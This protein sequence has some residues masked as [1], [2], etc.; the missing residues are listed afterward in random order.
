VGALCAD[1]PASGLVW[2]RVSALRQLGV[3][4]RCA[5]CLGHRD[6]VADVACGLSVLQN[7]YW[8]ADE[9]KTG[10]RNAVNSKTPAARRRFQNKNAF[11]ALQKSTVLQLRPSYGYS[12]GFALQK[13]GA[14]GGTFARSFATPHKGV[15]FQSQKSLERYLLTGFSVPLI[16]NTQVQQLSLLRAQHTELAEV[17]DLAQDFAQLVRLRQSAQFDAWLE[18]AATSTVSPLQR[19]AKGLGE[20]YAA[21][22][23]GITLPWSNGPVE[24]QINR[25][26]MLKRQM[27][28]RA[29]LDLLSRRFMLAPRHRV[30]R[31]QYFKPSGTPTER[32]MA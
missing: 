28:G 27:F 20:D 18:R 14:K 12:R 29:R 19:F 32:L 15:L 17:I 21:I 26:K 31:A 5:L 25:L 9:Q 2:Q 10:L 4:A 22:K 11:S 13:L 16:P 3:P 7:R 24:G 6:W 8:G 23:A 30:R 1:S